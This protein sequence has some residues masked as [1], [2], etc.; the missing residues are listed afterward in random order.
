MVASAISSTTA[1]TTQITQASI[2]QHTLVRNTVPCPCSS[3]RSRRPR[4][5]ARCS[6]RRA[7]RAV[8]AVDTEFVWERTYAPALCLVQLATAERLAV[9]D[10]LEGAP[11]EPVAELMADPAVEKVMHAP[12]GDLAAFVLHHDVRPRNIFD[13]QLAAG[14]VGFGGSPSLERLLDQ[15]VGVRLRHD[16]GF[17]DW[18]RRPLTP[19]QIEYAADDVRHLLA[20]AAAL[21]QRLAEQGRQAWV[22]EEMEQRYGAQATLVQDPDQAWRRVS[23]RGRLRGEQLSA[24]AAVAAWREREARRR[25]LPASWLIKDATLIE[26]ARRRPGTAREA[27]SIRG[28]QL[29]KGAQL[30]GLLAAVAAAG[31]MPPGADRGRAAE[32]GA[33]A[34]AGRAAA[35][36]RGAAGPL[37]RGAGRVGAGRDPGRARVADRR[38]GD[39]RRRRPPAPAGLAARA[40]GRVAAAAAARRGRAARAPARAARR[41]AADVSRY[42][43]APWVDASVTAP[44]VSVLAA[45]LVV[46]GLGKLRAPAAA[47]DAMR[48]AGLPSGA[49]GRGS[50]VRPRLG[51]G[52]LALVAPSRASLGALAASTRSWD[53]SRRGSC[54]GPSRSPRAGASAPMRLRR[55]LACR[56]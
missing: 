21:R 1:A 48:A 22:D 40:G 55:A 56:L 27:E 3:S 13:T 36:E 9:I 35:G 29:R 34:G 5:S 47:A 2:L 39:G 7:P 51:I 44:L 14:F 33:A 15:A 50:W 53:G 46:A 19:V 37:R 52:A 17:T 43:F 42:P 31:P 4:R 20:A 10:P 18:Q 45:V 49:V 30:D 25:D 6:T 8:C 16:E 41:R 38:P 23:G 11:L 12:S 24:L 28:L 54:A 26:L 32:R